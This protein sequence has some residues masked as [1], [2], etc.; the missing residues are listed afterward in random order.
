MEHKKKQQL[1][2]EYLSGNIS[3]EQIKLLEDWFYSFDDSEV[4][5]FTAVSVD[6]EK[7]KDELFEK[8]V[9][10]IKVND[11][12][13]V[14]VI[15][16]VKWKQ[17]FRWAASILVFLSI[18]FGVY[19]NNKYPKTSDNYTKTSD[20]QIVITKEGSK[21]KRIT[22]EDGSIVTLNSGSKIRYPKQFSSS[23]REV[24]LTGEAFFE[25]TKNP[26]KPFLVYANELIVT[27][28]GTSFN[29]RAFPN[30]KKVIVKVR[31]G[32][33]GVAV[34]QK[35]NDKNTRKVDNLILLP[36]QQVVFSRQEIKLVKS[37]IENPIL[38][39]ANSQTS[40]R[41]SFVFEAVPASDIF[42]VI[43]QAY[44]VDIVFE[45]E[46]FTNCQF[47]GNL[48]DLSLYEKLDIICKSIEANYQI[49]D[50]KIIVSGEGC[51]L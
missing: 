44:G 4:E 9:N 32:R 11:S 38:L 26:A 6:K 34:A 50:T 45:T 48:T 41:H 51:N 3:P 16:V 29:V 14:N 17:V 7:F 18:A 1:I 28:L 39:S 40:I 10:K 35:I 19:Y 46:L 25:V 33:V 27:V 49:L 22:L 23:K 43:E 15:K 36:N 30:D 12:E 8:I 21:Q 47:T 13:E 42:K 2:S 24:F 31:T 20:Y 37:L 5:I